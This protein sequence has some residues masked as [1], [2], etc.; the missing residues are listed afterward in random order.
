MAEDPN[1]VFRDLNDPNDPNSGDYEPEK[2]RIRALLTEMQTLA[3]EWSLARQVGQ[4]FFSSIRSTTG[5]VVG[6]GAYQFV[7]IDK[8]VHVEGIISISSSSGSGHVGAGNLPFTHRSFNS[9]AAIGTCRR[10]GDGIIGYSHVG[11]SSDQLTLVKGVDAGN[12]IAVQTYD[13]SIDYRIAD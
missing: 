11:P 10:Q 4:G 9:I 1:I 12:F 7:R 5:T 8:F 13:F 3:N 2:A 6:T